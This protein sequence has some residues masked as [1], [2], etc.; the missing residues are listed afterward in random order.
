MDRKEAFVNRATPRKTVQLRLPSGLILSAPVGKTLED[1]FVDAEAQRLLAF[2]APLIAAVCDGKLRELT[3]APQRDYDVRPITLADS[4]GGRIYRRSLVMLMVTA[5]NELWHG[6]HVRVNYAVRDGGFYCELEDREPLTVEQVGI[7]EA[8]MRQLVE[9]NHRISRRA[10]SKLEAEDVFAGRN[11]HDTLRLLQF[12]KKDTVPLYSLRGRP[13]YYFGYMV[14]STRYLETFKLIHMPDAFILQYPRR[15]SPTTLKPLRLY[16]KLSTVFQQAG[17]WLERIDVEDIG[18]LNQLVQSGKI[19]EIVLVAEALHEQNVARIA[20]RIQMRVQQGLRIVLIAGPSSS[21]KTTFSKRLSIQLLAQGIRP[22]TL[23]MDN[24]F[25]ERHLTPKDEN[26]EYDFEA[27][28]A[29]DRGI[30]NDHLLRLMRGEEIQLPRFDFR[31]GTRQPGQ[32]VQLQE[33]QVLILEG[34]H[35][36]NPEL[37]PRI[38]KEHIFRVYVSVLS[39]LNINM[40]NRV[41]TTDVRLLRRIVRDAR[42]RGYS[43]TDTLTRWQSVRRGE[44]RNIFPHQEQA[45]IM[46]NSG[47]AYEL[48]ALRSLAEPLLL[49]VQPG[50]EPHIEANRLLS[51]LEW[52]EP[53]SQTQF[54]MIP[55]TS[56]L[57]EFVGNSILEDYHPMHF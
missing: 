24:Y 29:M 10:V 13:D 15:E 53:L 1:I 52:V 57:R 51:F 49:Q 12:R 18:R 40:H 54:D 19:R 2:E 56:L 44:K 33:N 47:L 14:P 7:L 35:G 5:L 23:E 20:E 50:T 37:L 31:T 41:P 30:L 34:I 55:D 11:D 36:M 3:H 39:Q 45:D 6:A 48:A 38:S 26:G 27:L 8:R 21:G 46:F 28:E 17:E 22:F 4:D 16:Q 43:A 9:G 42:S 25:V 32:M